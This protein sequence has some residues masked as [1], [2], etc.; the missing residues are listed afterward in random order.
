MLGHAE[1]RKFYDA[2]GEK[3]NKQFYEEAATNLLLEKG[4]FDKA[5]SI[6]EFGCG[7]GKLASQLLNEIVPDD[8]KYLGIDISQTMVR[9]CQD[10]INPF[11]DRAACQQTT[12]EP[13]V[14]IPDQSTDRFVSL[15]VMDLLSEEDTISLM[16]EAQRILIPGGYL[17][18]ASLTHGTT[19]I[20]GAVTFIWRCLYRLKP[21][22]VGGCV[23]INL[24]R[25]LDEEKWEIRMDTAIVSFGVP[26]QVVIA[27]RL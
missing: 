7:T 1:V 4:E 24:T 16:R 10:N 25:F 5:H 2:F 11:A 17:C 15:Y 13:V 14:N 22:I 21:S 19:L 26:S 20:S 9:L 8:C 12:G 23:P 6:V 18:L 27:S 3:Q